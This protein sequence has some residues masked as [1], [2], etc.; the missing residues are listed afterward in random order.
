VKKRL[1]KTTYS[2]ALLLAVA[3][4]LPTLS[5]VP[6]G[7]IWLWQH[8]LVIYWA[9]A[10]CLIVAAIYLM[11][12]RLVTSLPA[13]PP[14]D[15]DESA[16][17]ADPNWTP[18]QDEAWA[19]VTRMASSV[20][21]ER[22]T[23]RDAVLRLG[24][25][26]IE[27][28]ARQLHPERKDPLLQ[29]TVPEALA[30]IERA[31][32][33]LRGFVVSSFPLGDRVTVA[34][35]MW[36]Y[37]WR[38]AVQ[39]AEKG[40]DLWRVVRLLNPASAVTQEL[41]ERFTRQ[42]YE[43]G[44]DHLARR[45]ARAFV[46][47][48]GRAAIDLYGGNLR[49]TEAQ[50]RAHVTAATREDMAEA[51]A[52]EAEPIRIL[53]AGQTG[54]GKSSLINALASA[55]QA[56]VD[57]LPTT[58]RFTAYRLTHEGL[59]AALIVD[60]P[61]LTGPKDHPELIEAADDCDMILWVVSATRAARDVDAQALAAIR[62][63]FAAQPNRRRP[64]MLLALT[65]IDQL[66]PFTEWQPPYDL[67]TAARG[68][69]VTIRDAI[70]ATGGE[71]G[72]AVDDI[73]PVRADPAAEPYNVD[74]LWAKLIELVPEAQRA[75]LLRTLADVKSAAG[76]TTVWSQAVSAGRVIKGTLLSRSASK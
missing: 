11:E 55:V 72:F 57:P 39:L 3:L 14:P 5:L 6:L 18:R 73:V 69:G 7:T 16:A 1:D 43:A 46:R 41:R 67:A 44:R 33:N 74:A 59:P 49:V 47:E 34:Q 13:A 38:G 8:G 12:K 31:S 26:T 68:K 42:L 9:V 60:S 2:R 29:F 30:V 45:L 75:R 28:V 22:L 50:L 66:R 65:H 19:A 40:Y 20:G 10:A 27:T 54:A 23:S 52:R 56:V 37:R 53:V 58:A 36:L 62:G 4:L 51:E 32:A 24:L 17:P 15:E 25:D 48:V 35:I 64:P 61:G 21:P 70:Q 76:W 71:L 63:H